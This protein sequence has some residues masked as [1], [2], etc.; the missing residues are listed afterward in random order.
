MR[1]EIFNPATGFVDPAGRVAD[2][3]KYAEGLNS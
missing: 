3:K 2:P 1:Y